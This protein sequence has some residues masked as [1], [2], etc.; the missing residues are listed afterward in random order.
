MAP[1]WKVMLSRSSPLY[2]DSLF[3]FSL[4]EWRAQE[5]ELQLLRR[6]AE[7]DRRVLLAQ[8]AR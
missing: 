6:L 1:L 3:S 8:L 7:Q 4:W 5:R 2:R